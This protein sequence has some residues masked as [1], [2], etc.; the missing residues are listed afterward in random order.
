MDYSDLNELMAETESPLYQDFN[1][2]AEYL[3]SHHDKLMPD[4]L[5]DLYAFYKQGVVGDCNVQKPGIFQMTSRAKW[6]AWDHLRGMSNDEAMQKY[7]DKIDD[8]FPQWRVSDPS[9]TTSTSW[10]ATSRPHFDEDMDDV[11][12]TLIDFVQD[13]NLT[14]VNEFLTRLKATEV[15]ELDEQGM[16]LIHWCSDRGHEELL[17]MLLAHPGIDV[18]LRDEDGQTALHYSSSCGHLGCLK[19]LVQAGADQS[20]C[21]NEGNTFLSVAYD[22]SVADVVNQMKSQC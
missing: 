20:I 5:L 2:A 8:S 11:G 18:N 3:K 21:D 13:G 9:E 4:V 14:Q 12:K 16:G 17:R 1:K 15:N 22:D 6:S 19:I 10:V 7:V